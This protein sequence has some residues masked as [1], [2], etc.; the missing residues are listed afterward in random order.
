[1]VVMMMVMMMMMMVV[2]MMIMIMIMMM[3]F[4]MIVVMMMMMTMI[5]SLLNR[6]S[7]G[8][9]VHVRHE[10]RDQIRVQEAAQAA[11][12]VPLPGQLARHGGARGHEPPQRARREVRLARTGNPSPL[13]LVTFLMWDH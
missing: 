13:T 8:H 5:R 2:M 1:V 9:Q 6:V 12:V 10:L 7:S 3:L 4:L 11:G